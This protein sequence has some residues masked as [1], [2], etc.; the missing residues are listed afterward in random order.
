MVASENI[1]TSV[2]LII[3]MIVSGLVIYNETTNFIISEYEFDKKQYLYDLYS[4]E[5]NTFLKLTD[6]G[7]SNSELLIQSLTGEDFKIENDGD[8]IDVGENIKDYFDELLDADKYYFEVYDEIKEFDLNL[9]IDGNLTDEKNYLFLELNKIIY[10]TKINVFKNK[11]FKINTN[12]FIFGNSSLGNLCREFRYLHPDLKCYI[13]DV[14]RYYLE[15]KKLIEYSEISSVKK[16]LILNNENEGLFLG[17]KENLVHDYY[18]QDDNVVLNKIQN[19]VE[20]KVI[21]EV[22]SMKL[23][24]GKKKDID[25]KFVIRRV[26]PIS[27]DN[28][29]IIKLEVYS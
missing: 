9:V 18:N 17:F 11:E 2:M 24:V 8:N 20:K 5:L 6:D 26:L 19:F 10:Y 23:R 7:V 15:K 1:L 12:I 22:D 29:G 27:I 3:V 4:N 28:K 13:L 14:G 25:D 21:D 16:N